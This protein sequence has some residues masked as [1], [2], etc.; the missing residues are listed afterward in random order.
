[1]CSCLGIS[2][3]AHFSRYMLHSNTK[4]TNS[5]NQSNQ[6]TQ[7][8]D[9]AH[10]CHRPQPHTQ[11]LYTT[12]IWYNYNY[13]FDKVNLDMENMYNFY[14]QQHQNSKNNFHILCNFLD[15]LGKMEGNISDSF[16]SSQNHNLK[17]IECRFWGSVYINNSL[18]P[19][20]F[21]KCYQLT[22][23]KYHIRC[24]SKDLWYKRNIG[25]L[26]KVDKFLTANYNENCIL[27]R[28]WAHSHIGYILVSQENK[29]D[30]MRSAR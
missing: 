17:N 24:I 4:N 22:H 2:Y 18:N 30:L 8:D 28:Q 9:K 19:S 6:D 27:Y 25:C 5:N 14:Q 20:I 29:F 7:F 21:Y 3:S 23:N 13:T 16:C 10:I 11:Q 26:D 12:Y 1:M 15:K